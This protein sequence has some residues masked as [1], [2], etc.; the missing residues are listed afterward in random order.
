MKGL[1]IEGD[2]TAWGACCGPEVQALIEH[3]ILEHIHKIIPK[4][5][6]MMNAA[7]AYVTHINKLKL[8][9]TRQL[10][11]TGQEV[12]PLGS[13]GKRDDV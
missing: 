5:I 11:K 2:G 1:H 8:G 6:G 10:D 4:N 12:R 3:R 13:S 9:G 7:G